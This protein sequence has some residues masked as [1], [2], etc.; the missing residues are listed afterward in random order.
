MAEQSHA[1]TAPAPIE[2]PKFVTVIVERP[3]FVEKIVEVEKVKIVTVEKEYERPVAKDVPY[4]RPVPYNQPYER[5]VLRDKEYHIPV[6]IRDEHLVAVTRAD[7]ERL[8][9][10]VELL[11]VVLAKLE[12]IVKWEP[13][14]EEILVQKPVLTPI[15]VVVERPKFKDVSVER[16]TYHDVV[17]EKP[18]VR[19][20]VIIVKRLAVRNEQT[21]E[22]EFVGYGKE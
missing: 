13:R 16:P 12:Q 8:Q 17:Y 22:L 10:A 20:Q 1:S 11:P 5:P 9:K 4:E 18:V 7:F 2:V 6:I 21:G 3:K 19:E 14:V 15:E